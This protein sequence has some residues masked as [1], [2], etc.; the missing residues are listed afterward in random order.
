MDR[1]IG[2]VGAG[3][4]GRGMAANLVEHGYSVKIY[5]RTRSRAEDVASGRCTVVDSPAE[6]AQGA[7]VIVTVLSDT[8]A[9]QAVVE[10]PDG[11]AGVIE[12]G[13]TLIDCSTISPAGS[14]E[15]ARLLPPRGSSMLDAPLLGSK[16]EAAKGTLR[17]VVGG[18][19]E[20]FEGVADVFSAMGDRAYYMGSNGMGLYAKL[21]FN[22]VIALN[23][24]ALNEGLVFATR[25][26][27]EPGQMFEILQFGRAKSGI[28][29]AKGPKILARDFEPF[30]RLALMDKDL[31]IVLEEA[32]RQHVPLPGVAAA[33]QLFTAAIAAGQADEDMCSVIRQLERGAAV[34]VAARTPDSE[35]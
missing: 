8:A 5:N 22:L 11:I 6:A 7:Q 15:L 30:F 18:S 2:F 28:A 26:G 12:A 1:S 10:G 34:E 23:L 21:T 32:H 27:I 4:M 33:K 20:V 25:A 24:E 13:A 35:A 16:A 31:E 19:R 29:E 9:V 17:F 3:A 14:I